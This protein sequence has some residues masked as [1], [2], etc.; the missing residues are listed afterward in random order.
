MAA[1]DAT[2]VTVNAE[3]IK[4]EISE[5]ISELE[6]ITTIQKEPKYALAEL[7]GRK[8]VFVCRSSDWLLCDVGRSFATLI[9]WRSLSRQVLYIPKSRL[10]LWEGTSE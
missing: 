9:G 8:D 4:Q 1:P 3:M 5:V 2:S 6:S 10:I 7:I